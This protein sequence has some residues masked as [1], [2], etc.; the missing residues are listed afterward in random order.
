MDVNQLSGIL[1]CVECGSH[2]TAARPDGAT[3]TACGEVYTAVNG[4][5][6]LRPRH[7][8]LPL[9]R[10]Y[11]DPHYREWQAR[12]AKA[13]DYFYGGNPIMRW[14]QEAG[15]RHVTRMTRR[16]ARGLTLD[17]GC[18]DGAHRPYLNGSAGR[19]VGLDIDQ[20]S[21][22]KARR[23]HPDYF[24]LRGNAFNLPFADAAFERVLNIYNLEHVL[25]LDWVLEEVARV[26][27]PGGE[28]LVSV[29]TEGGLA[30]TL[31]RRISSARQL[32]TGGLD[33]ARSNQIDHCNCAWQIQKA[34]QRH[35]SIDAGR[36]FPTGVPSFHTNLI[37][38][39]RLT[40]REA[41]PA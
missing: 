4:I 9:P 20:A 10:M 19:C 12:L 34:L 18:G 6:D 30:W 15:H 31:G 32:S 21:L 37:C 22:E 26:L 29:P 7:N 40:R 25:Y 13:Q 5:L 27:K 33:Y 14:V 36:W 17:L 2:D 3:C 41:Q 39:W 16:E 28:F 23:R 35:F 11:D 38:T 1:R 8:V 24:V